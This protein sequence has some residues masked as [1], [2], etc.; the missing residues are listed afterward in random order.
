MFGRWVEIEFDCLPLRSVPRMDA[1]ID[2][3]PRYQQFVQ[4][5]KAAMAKHGSHNTYYLHRGK[6]RYY[7]TND[8]QIGMVEFAFEGSVMTGE[9]D[10]KTKALELSVELSGETCAWLTEP[11]VELLA[12]SAERAVMVEFDRYIEAGDLQKTEERIKAI[13]EQSDAEGGFLGMYL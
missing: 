8:P 7:L 13:Q 1:P 5:I 6:C 4:R 3:S 11:M 2:A 9:K 10:L 12:Q